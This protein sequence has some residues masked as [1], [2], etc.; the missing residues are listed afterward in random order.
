[1]VM[2]V[3]FYIVN[4]SHIPQSEAILDSDCGMWV[5][6]YS[7]CF[8]VALLFYARFFK[9]GKRR[10]SSLPVYLLMSYNFVSPA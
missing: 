3:L 7:S 5:V 8:L 10:F 2:S 9:G 6:C 4:C 1:M